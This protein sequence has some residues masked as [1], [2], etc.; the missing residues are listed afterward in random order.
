[1]NQFTI[2]SYKVFCEIVYESIFKSICEQKLEIN[3][4]PY[5]EVYFTKETLQF[6]LN[7]QC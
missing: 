6:Y 1:M 2:D 3:T 7:S 4:K 5:E